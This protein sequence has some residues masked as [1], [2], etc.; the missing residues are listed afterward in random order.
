MLKIQHKGLVV[1]MPYDSAQ[2]TGDPIVDRTNTY[3]QGL[4]AGRI[5]SLNSDG[6]KL[7]DGSAEHAV[8]FIVNDAV[9][10]PLENMPA[11][12]SKKAAVTLGNQTIVTDQID[13]ALSFAIGQ[14]IYAGTGAKVGLCTNVNPQAIS[15]AGGVLDSV[16]TITAIGGSNGNI[17]VTTVDQA[18]L[19]GGT[20]VIT[21]DGSTLI[22]EIDDGVTTELELKNGLEAHSM[23]VSAATSTDGN[24]VNAA[25]VTLSGGVDA[26]PHIGIAGSTASNSAPDLTIHIV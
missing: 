24:P 21:F 1:N 16:L 9:A 20:G 7:C 22:I 3:L 25:S 11:S 17:T 12:A 23:I 19:S 15:S 10:N 4:L 5:A 6:I 14:K 2:I 8:G 18:S 26:G 13:T